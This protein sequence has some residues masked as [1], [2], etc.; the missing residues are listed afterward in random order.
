MKKSDCHPCMQLTED[1]HPVCRFMKKEIRLME[2]CPK[3]VDT[4]EPWT[5]EEYKRLLRL[6]SGGTHLRN[7]ALVL[8]RPYEDVKDKLNEAI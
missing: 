6:S 5:P 7:V 2:T 8:K 4:E 1:P 3:D